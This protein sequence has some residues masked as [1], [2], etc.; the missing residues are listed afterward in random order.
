MV[1]CRNLQIFKSKFLV[2]CFT[3]TNKK[4]IISFDDVPLLKDPAEM[5]LNV[6]EVYYKFSKSDSTSQKIIYIFYIENSGAKSR[7][8]QITT[9]EKNK[10]TK[11]VLG[12]SST[13]NQKGKI[14]QFLK[15]RTEKLVQLNK[16]EKQHAS[17]I[18]NSQQHPFVLERAMS[19]LFL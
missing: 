14:K 2:E 18:N 8:E 12:T 7:A 11:V 10:G 3:D 1:K 19:N 15:N 9:N 6:L 5:S 16:L 4:K 13:T 17:S